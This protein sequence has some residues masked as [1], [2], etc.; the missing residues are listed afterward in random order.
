MLTLVKIA[1]NAALITGITEL[2][3]RSL[4][5]AALLG[6]LPIVTII[7]MIWMHAEGKD[8]DSIAGYSTATFWL[9]LPTLP[10]FLVFPALVKAGSGFWFALLVSIVVM[11]V[12]Y[13]L[14]LLLLRVVGIAI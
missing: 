7:S 10:M 1:V 13:G 9:V 14:L 11:L 2:V 5:A 12:L 6:A 8:V 3:K 4:H